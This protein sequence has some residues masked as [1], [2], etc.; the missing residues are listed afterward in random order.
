MT[1][2]RH[3]ECAIVF[4]ADGNSK[5]ELEESTTVCSVFHVFFV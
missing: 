5:N 4:V 3:T 2:Y 1:Y